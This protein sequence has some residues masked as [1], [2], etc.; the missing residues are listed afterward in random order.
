MARSA[1]GRPTLIVLSIGALV[2]ATVAADAHLGHVQHVRAPVVRFDSGAVRGV[3][4]AGVDSFLGIRYA[5]PPVG[6]LRW[7]PPQSADPWPGV[8]DADRYGNRCP[9]T[10]G[11]NGPRSET[12][13]CLFVNVHRPAGLARGER[14]PVYVFIHGGSLMEGSSNQADLAAFV[15]ATGVV[16]VSLNYRL[17]ALGFLA[18]PGLTAEQGQSG[19]YGLMDQQEALRWVQ[20]NIAAFGGDPGRVTIGG[21]SAGGWSV[22]T[23]LVAP[24]SRGLFT[25]AVLLSGSCPSTTEAEAEDVGTRIAGAVGCTDAA[26]ALSCLR[27][28]PVA[29]LLAAG[30]PS[31]D[32]MP[33]PVRGIPFLPDDPRKAVATGHFTRVPVL[34]GA[35]R[36]E[37]RFFA[38]SFIGWSRDQYEGW[39]RQSFPTH[40][41]AVLARYPWPAASDRFTAAYLAGAVFTDSGLLAGIGGCSHRA[42]TRD[43]ARYVPTWAYEFDHRTGPGPTPIPGYEWGAA[44]AAVLFYLFP[45]LDIGTPIA[46]TFD[47]AERQLAGEMTQYWA[48]FI[49]QSQPGV[50]GQADWPRYRSPDYLTLSLRA[51]GASTTIPDEKLAAEHQCGF[52]DAVP[53]NSR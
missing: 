22:C 40:V 3:R 12:E 9:V 43:L 42:L 48:A 41:Q 5:A 38:Q 28:A 31:A 44:H 16:G 4:S 7:R 2:L 35:S 6:S 24:G 49:R 1:L 30:Y 26:T 51:G 46:A 27:N 36:D 10:A 23:H 45:S 14:R 52:W 33:F 15:T 19:D 21:E 18:H 47:P 25:G 29:A 34:V 8:L 53:G 32:W 37:G 17:G 50:H 13:D 20:R 39:V 11:T